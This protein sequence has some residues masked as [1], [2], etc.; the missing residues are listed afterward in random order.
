MIITIELEDS[1]KVKSVVCD[2]PTLTIDKSFVKTLS[3]ELNTFYTKAR[4][5]KVDTSLISTSAILDIRR[6]YD[7]QKYNNPFL[8]LFGKHQSQF[9]YTLAYRVAEGVISY[10]DVDSTFIAMHSAAA[11][12]IMDFFNGLHLHSAK[13]TI[14]MVLCDFI[15]TMLD[16]KVS[17]SAEA[18]GIKTL[19]EWCNSG[20][21]SLTEIEDCFLWM[22]KSGRGYKLSYNS[23]VAAMPEFDR[24]KFQNQYGRYEGKPL[25]FVQKEDTTKERLAS[26][27]YN[28]IAD[29]AKQVSANRKEALKGLLKNE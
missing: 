14:N 15:Y 10:D 19:L 13:Y 27:N 5:K 25:G 9:Y 8:G 12:S 6:K 1:L 4:K 16:G 24:V 3:A 22:P 18:K 11:F 26:R 21:T 7:L 2:D 28:D 20:K 29:K 17:H 23:L